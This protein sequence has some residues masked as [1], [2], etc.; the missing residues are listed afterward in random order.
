MFRFVLIGIALTIIIF[1]F[2]VL[3]PKFKIKY[4]LNKELK[5]KQKRLQKFKKKMEELEIK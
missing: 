4:R 3:V 1:T 5:E 2:D